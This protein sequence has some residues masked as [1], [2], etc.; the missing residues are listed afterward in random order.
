VLSLKQEL[1]DNLNYIHPNMTNFLEELSIVFLEEKTYLLTCSYPE[2]GQTYLNYTTMFTHVLRLDPAAELLRTRSGSV[3]NESDCFS[4]TDDIAVRDGGFTR[5]MVPSRLTVV[6][7]SED[8]TK[9]NPE[10][11][12]M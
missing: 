3:S 12:T 9:L 8:L 5:Y 1:S 11:P 2:V 10:T 6:G 7:H 4:V